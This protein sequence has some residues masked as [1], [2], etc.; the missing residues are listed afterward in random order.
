M[1]HRLDIQD[2]ENSSISETTCVHQPQKHQLTVARWTSW[3][4]LLISIVVVFGFLVTLSSQPSYSP[5]EIELWNHIIRRKQIRGQYATSDFGIL[6]Y[7]IL[8]STCFSMVCTKSEN[9]CTEVP[10]VTRLFRLLPSSTSPRCVRFRVG[11]FGR[12]W[13]VV[14]SCCFYSCALRVP[15]QWQRGWFGVG[16]ALDCIRH[17]VQQLDAMGHLIFSEKEVNIRQSTEP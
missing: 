17:L 3:A 8:V 10:G 2:L 14:V 6:W 4:T 11:L 13:D 7:G 9:C 12:D 15:W 1:W 5:F 16:Q